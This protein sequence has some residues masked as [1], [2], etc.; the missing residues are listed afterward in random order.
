MSGFLPLM[1]TRGVRTSNPAEL[2]HSRHSSQHDK[3][4]LMSSRADKMVQDN[5]DYFAH[6]EENSLLHSAGVIAMHLF[7][8]FNNAKQPLV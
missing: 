1:R 8:T 5:V 7:H 6:V 2:N 4:R 3:Q